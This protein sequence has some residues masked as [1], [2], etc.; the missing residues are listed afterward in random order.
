[1]SPAPIN[2]SAVETVL[3]SLRRELRRGQR[4]L[5]RDPRGTV[6]AAVKQL[7]SLGRARPSAE[8]DRDPERRTY[9]IDEL[10]R[11]SNVT[12]RNIRAYQERGLLPPPERVGR[13]ALFDDSHLSRLK[14]ITSMLERGYSSAHLTEM[15]SAWEHGR[16]LADVIGLEGALVAAHVGD[17]PVTMTRADARSLA[18]GQVDLAVLVDAGLV[19]LHGDRAR[20]LRPELLRSFAEMR[21]FGMSTKALVALHQE[22]SVSVDEITRRL[23]DEGIRQVGTRFLDGAEPTGEEVGEL[24]AML[25]RFRT[26]AL[27]TVSATL[28]SSLE[29]RVED[30]LGDYLAQYAKSATTDAG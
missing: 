27:T 30:V 4:Q 22:V 16:D 28:A 1:M 2:P 18:G 5:A 12:V 26:L 17:D 19:E 6:E 13:V 9:R 21:D 29:R 24:V 7:L 3:E 11:R 25:T 20:V 15:L 23:V 14:I 10:A 8:P